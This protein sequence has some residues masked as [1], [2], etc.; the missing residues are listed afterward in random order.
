MAQLDASRIGLASVG[1]DVRIYDFARLTAPERIT[2][3]NHVIVD[4]FVFLQG[5]LGLSVG[6][7]VHI[8]S[9]ASVTGGGEGVIGNFAGMAPGARI[10][11]GSDLADGSGMV[12]PTIPAEYRAVERSRTV[13][14]EHSFVCANAVVL[15]GIT[16]GE[17]AVLGAGAVATKDLEPWT[18]YAGTP[19]RAVKER[20]AAT[21]LANA[22]KLQS[23]T[24]PGR[25]VA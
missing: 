11:T 9:Y 10:L 8:A 2:I 7:Y 19:A 20:P 15:A 5:G 6:S 23:N 14:G 22:R 21:I 3:G 17:G 12:G 24:T 4:D 16:V 18:I 13:L 25:L 1:E